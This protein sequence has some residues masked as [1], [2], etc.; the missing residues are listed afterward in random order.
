MQCMIAGK[1]FHFR[2]K[3]ACADHIPNYYGVSERG[4]EDRGGGGH[5]HSRLHTT[6][7]TRG[8][9]AGGQK[10]QKFD[11]QFFSEAVLCATKLKGRGD[12]GSDLR[13][14]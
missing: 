11:S 1:H 7:L 13:R 10:K 3:W 4:E 12:I 9:E 14:N 5:F 8:G 6:P 2:A